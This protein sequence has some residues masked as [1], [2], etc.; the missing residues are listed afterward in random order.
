MNEKN[1]VGLIGLGLVG[2]AISQRLIGSGYDVAGYDI[3]GKTPEAVIN[4]SNAVEVI[5]RCHRVVFCLPSSDVVMKVVQDCG[6]HF[7]KEHVIIDTGTGSPEEVSRVS[8]MLK[9][10]GASFFEATIAG[11]SELLKKKKAQLFLSGDKDL[12]DRESDLID[13]LTEK[14]FY[15]GA[16]GMASKFKLVHNLIIGLN[17]AVLAEGLQFAES[18]GFDSKEVLSILKETPAYSSVMDTKGDRMVN[19]DYSL[20]QARVAQ[21]LKDVKLIVKE[22]EKFNSLTPISILHESLLESIV[23]RGFGGEDNSAIMEAF[24]HPDEF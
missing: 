19:R 12:I 13:S 20:P 16:L 4:C 10:V 14:S 7:T 5:S 22:S 2:T 23:D 3:S 21:H 9:S 8:E 1:T 17:R 15:L 18:Y 24:N 11:S 6:D